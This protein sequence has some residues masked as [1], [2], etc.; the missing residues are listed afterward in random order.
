MSHQERLKQAEQ[1]L[2]EV[3]R[4]PFKYRP[5]LVELFLR[6]IQAEMAEREA[7]AK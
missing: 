1:S 6:E 3:V 7:G 4:R 2:L 5:K